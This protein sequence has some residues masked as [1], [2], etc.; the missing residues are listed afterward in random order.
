[1][2]VAACIMIIGGFYG[3]WAA[4]RTSNTHLSVFFGVMIIS[5]LLLL[6]SGV[7]GV[8]LP[9]RIATAGCGAPIYPII[10]GLN[11]TATQAINTICQTCTCFINN[12][13]MQGSFVGYNIDTVNSAQPTKAQACTSPAW[14]KTAY[15]DLYASLETTF[16]CSGWCPGT[17]GVMYKMTNTNGGTKFLIKVLLLVLASRPQPI[18]SRFSVARSRL[19]PLYS[20]HSSSY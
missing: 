15:D 16:S 20:L 17:Q 12:T 6:V 14:N 3:T 7:L 2:I 11:I 8:A 1:M 19:A 18:G 9:L 13:I 4:Y 5:T 10:A